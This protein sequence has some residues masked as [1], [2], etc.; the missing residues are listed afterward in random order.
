MREKVL[1]NQ[2]SQRLAGE[3]AIV[4]DGGNGLGRAIGSHLAR[5]GADIAVVA[6]HHPLQAQAVAEEIKAIGSRAL[7][8]VAD[9]TDG[10]VVNKMVEE[11][12]AHFGRVDILINNAGVPGVR[13]PLVE[14]SE[15]DWDR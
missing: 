3:V 10:N 5:E 11:A 4:T 6:G 9:V 2:I 1:P 13:K 14:I 12:G 7:P 15:Q 8:L